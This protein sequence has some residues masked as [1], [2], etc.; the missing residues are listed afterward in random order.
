MQNECVLVLMPVQARARRVRPF[1]KRQGLA[2][3][4]DARAWRQAPPRR[5][6][7]RPERLAGLAGQPAERRLSSMQV[8]MKKW[9]V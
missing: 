4:G 6:R 2:V 5:F 9:E 1:F 3:S 7:Q 8:C